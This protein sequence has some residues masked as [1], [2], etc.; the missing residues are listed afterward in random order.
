LAA[1]ATERPKFRRPSTEFD[2]PAAS[3]RVSALNRWQRKFDFPL[4]RTHSW[5]GTISMRNSKVSGKWRL[6]SSRH[7]LDGVEVLSFDALQRA[8]AGVGH[9]DIASAYY[10]ARYFAHLFNWGGIVG[11]GERLRLI[12][13]GL[14]GARLDAQR[15]EL[16]ALAKQVKKRF[17]R[18]EIRLAFEPGIFHSKLLLLR[19][20]NS[21]TAFV[22]SAN[23]TEAAML[24]NEE[25][26]LE[27][28]GATRP[29]VDYFESVWRASKELDDLDEKLRCR[30]LI[31]FF[32]T[33]KLYFKPTATLHLTL[34]P[35]SEV[36]GAL[37]PVERER[38][39]G[40]PLPFSE[41]TTGVGPFNIGQALG[42][43]KTGSVEKDIEKQAKF[44]LRPFAVETCFGYWVPSALSA[45]VRKKLDKVASKKYAKWAG[46]RA[47]IEKVGLKVLRSRYQAYLDAAEMRFKAEKIAWQTHIEKG[48]HDP[49][50]IAAFENFL[51]RLQKKLASPEYLSRLCDPFVPGSMPEI[52]DDLV[53]RDEFEETFFGFLSYVSGLDT[54]PSVSR[55]ILA[56]AGQSKY[57]DSDQIKK[58]LIAHP[59]AHGWAHD[60]WLGAK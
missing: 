29:L 15:N 16:E 11:K 48:A 46:V 44:S 30:G 58:G 54:Q 45:I 20:G 19:K 55:Q 39:G 21:R 18:V 42:E 40:Q 25:I 27:I 2:R 35:F 32:R 36:L 34:N 49:F 26:L 17:G 4:R 7:A 24:V 22:G 51:A 23:T 28:S 37:S 43:K 6:L 47:A 1:T 50:D 53:A 57:A 31:P 52:W 12:F 41:T 59:N 60:D 8:L 13:N 33:G 38:L 14:G 3:F 5:Y 10:D 56:S 9:V